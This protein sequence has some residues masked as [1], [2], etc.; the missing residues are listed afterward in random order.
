MIVM[1]GA[2]SFVYFANEWAL[3]MSAVSLVRIILF[4][5]WTE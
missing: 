1:R 2:P 5:K 4:D 3:R